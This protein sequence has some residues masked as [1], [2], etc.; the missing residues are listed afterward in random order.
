MIHPCVLTGLQRNNDGRLRRRVRL[1]GVVDMAEDPRRADLDNFDSSTL[2]RA[3]WRISELL[4]S[5]Q[6]RPQRQ[7]PIHI[8]TV[9]YA[10]A[11]VE[12]GEGPTIWWTQLPNK[13]VVD[14]A[15]WR[16]IG[17]ALGP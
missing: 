12:F 15:P 11:N 9:R 5:A 3:R 16:S 2:K 10:V 7:R 6:A 13:F 4:E 1:V 8:L 17:V 14:G